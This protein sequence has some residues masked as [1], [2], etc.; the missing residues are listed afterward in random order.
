M[1]PGLKER[2]FKSS[3]LHLGVNHFQQQPCLLLS[4]G[5]SSPAHV[6]STP[7]FH[8][9]INKCPYTSEE[10]SFPKMFPHVISRSCHGS[11]D[12]GHMSKARK[13]IPA[14]TMLSCGGRECKIKCLSLGSLPFKIH[15]SRWHNLQWQRA[16]LHFPCH[17]SDKAGQHQWEAKPLYSKSSCKS[18]WKEQ[19]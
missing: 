2:L 8:S 14:A 3:S 18:I 7:H 9:I 19:I 17:P 4:V 6:T 15:F 5:M 11:P 1:G 16:N 10:W 13:G 12:S